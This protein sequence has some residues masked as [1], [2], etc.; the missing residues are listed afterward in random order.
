MFYALPPHLDKKNQWRSDPTGCFFLEKPK[1][2]NGRY[3]CSVISTYVV[4][5]D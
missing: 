2:I 1:D 5:K 4:V 3:N